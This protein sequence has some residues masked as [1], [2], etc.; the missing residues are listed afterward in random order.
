PVR[1]PD[2]VFSYTRALRFAAP[3]LEVLRSPIGS[4]L[5]KVVTVAAPLADPI[6]GVY[7]RFLSLA[8]RPVL[9]DPYFKAMFLHDMI[10]AR[11]LRSVA[12]DLALFARHW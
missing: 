11:D 2:A 5:G 9:S 10:T 8:D 4:A 6:F 12:H 3:T 1:G 7:A